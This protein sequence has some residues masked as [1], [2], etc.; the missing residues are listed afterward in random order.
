MLRIPNLPRWRKTCCIIA[1]ETIKR[2]LLVAIGEECID[3]RDREKRNGLIYEMG[4][5]YFLC[6]NYVKERKVTRSAACGGKI[7]TSLRTCHGDVATTAAW[8]VEN[9]RWYASECDDDLTLVK[10]CQRKDKGTSGKSGCTWKLWVQV[11][12]LAQAN[13]NQQVD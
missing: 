11:R 3:I 2:R 10:W 9:W 13:I 1:G 8:D 6:E 4:S 5:N 7:F 12:S